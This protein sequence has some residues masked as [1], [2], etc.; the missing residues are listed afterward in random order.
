MVDLAIHALT[1]GGLC[2][3][4][5]HTSVSERVTGEDPT[6]N[7]V[8]S[9]TVARFFLVIELGFYSGIELQGCQY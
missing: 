1:F 5:R 8:L 4:L 7:R 2:L 6:L 9:C 3:V